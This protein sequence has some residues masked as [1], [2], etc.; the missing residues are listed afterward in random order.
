MLTWVWHSAKAVCCGVPI[1]VPSEHVGARRSRDSTANE[2]AAIAAHSSPRAPLLHALSTLA[3][4]KFWADV[5]L[6]F[7]KASAP[8][9][10]HH[11]TNN[12]SRRA[13]ST[14]SSSRLALENSPSPTSTFCQTHRHLATHVQPS[15]F[16]I[17]FNDI[18][19]PE[20]PFVDP[21]SY[22]QNPQATQ[23]PPNESRFDW[24]KRAPSRIR[25]SKNSNQPYVRKKF[26]K[27][28][29]PPHLPGAKFR[30]EIKAYQER[31]V[32]LR[33]Q[34]SPM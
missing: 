5:R 20:E 6:V 17:D 15:P 19:P 34:F 30:H 10:T 3:T 16:G 26:I 4:T 32:Y 29:E 12:A 11:Q 8:A 18:A 7:W 22:L 31:C 27:R 25:Q 21:T 33:S 2:K 24:R 1:M 28:I 23:S 13:H 14:T 9:R